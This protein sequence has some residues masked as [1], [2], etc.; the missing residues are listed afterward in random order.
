MFFDKIEENLLRLLIKQVWS[1]VKYD[2]F[3]R[4]KNFQISQ[5]LT[6]GLGSFQPPD[7]EAFDLDAEEEND[8]YQAAIETLL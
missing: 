2:K 8:L 7:Q 4:Q 5:A 3:V 1:H 6:A